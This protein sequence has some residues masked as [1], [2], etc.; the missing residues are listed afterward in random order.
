[1]NCSE[2]NW[3]FIYNRMRNQSV[4]KRN[5]PSDRTFVNDEE[6]KKR[7]VFCPIDHDASGFSE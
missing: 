4:E 5:T 1:M 7:S 3:F 2:N 6:L